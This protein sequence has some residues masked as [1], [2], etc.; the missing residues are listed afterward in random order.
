MIQIQTFLQTVL[1]FAFALG[2]L[3]IIHELGHYFVAR[4]CGVKVLR[5]SVGMGRVIYSKNFGKDQTEWALSILPLGGYVKMLDAR[6]QD[7]SKLSEHELSREFCRQSVWKRIA[8]VAAGP[9]ANFLLAITLFSGLYLHGVSE[10]SSKIRV[11]SSSSLAYHAGLRQGDVITS[12]NDENVQT[13]SDVRWKLLQLGLS[14]SNAQIVVARVSQNK[15]EILD[16]VTIELPLSQLSSKDLEADFLNQLGFSVARPAAILGTVDP[17]G[18]AKRAGLQE[19]DQILE[20]DGRPLLDG[21]AFTELVS[22]SPNKAMHLLVK[23]GERT[24]ELDVT[25]EQQVIKDQT[26]GRIKVGLM[27]AP[28]MVQVETTFSDSVVKGTK[29]TWDTSILNF[30][31]LGKMVTGDIS[32]KNITGPI[33][34]ADYAGQT[35][36]TSVVSYLSFIALISISL[37]VMN[38]LPI[39]VLDG[40]HLLY[41][42]LEVLTGRAVSERFGEIAQ[43]AGV[44]LL[45]GLM[46]VAFFNDISRLMS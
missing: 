39:P 13:W 30:K 23:R 25:P 14:K 43:R 8:I 44:V 1:A 46:A 6:E 27:L 35:S 10:P 31:M 26:I 9:T 21:L 17:E 2:T 33:T 4:L 36:R 18:A 7:V 12:V 45:M 19:K 41:Y 37:G 11:P 28:E 15:P 42:S 22:A 40:G 34:I 32:L 5:F 16:H 24:F 20:V 29:R 3:V 38:L